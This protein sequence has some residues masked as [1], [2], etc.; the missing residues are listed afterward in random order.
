MKEI[1]VPGLIDV[2]T[3]CRQPGGNHKEIF[4]TATQAAV[5]GGF[6]T[7]LDMPNNAIPTTSH[8]ALQQKIAFAQGNIYC[9]LGFNFGATAINGLDCQNLQNRYF[10]LK[11]YMN[12][13]T[14]DLLVE[15]QSERE[16]VFRLCPPEKI[17]MIHGEGDTLAQAILLAK[18]YQ[19]KIHI[20][21]VSLKEEIDMIRQA[22]NEG[23][24]ITCEVT[25]HHLFLTRDD[26]QFLGSYGKMRPPLA[27]QKDQD[28]LWEGIADGT[29]D[30]IA[31]DH[32][33]HTKEEKES[34]NSPSGV[35]G[36]ETTLP[37][38]L[39]AVDQKRLEIDHLI[40]LLTDRP[41][42]IF[43]I[44]PT[45]LTGVM[46]ESGKFTIDNSHLFTKC[47]WSPFNGR[48]VNWR[49][50]EVALRGRKIFDHGEFVGEPRGKV[51]HPMLS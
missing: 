50:T 24:P 11:L 49:V 37:L 25:P 34:D 26:E 46:V 1:L 33:P 21:H 18:K 27:T 45:I 3:H 51:I 2:H 12:R 5:A 23:L 4:A 36:L 29:V 22:K 30:M 41:G 39:T 10:G 8:K 15:N 6:T 40:D 38:M 16:T 32:A 7:I 44:P 13:T 9:D 19:R 35:P 28:S 47:A 48:P 20:C 14:G 31:S 43:G 42:Q 17:I